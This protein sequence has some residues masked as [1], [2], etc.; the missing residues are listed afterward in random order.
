MPKKTQATHADTYTDITMVIARTHGGQTNY[1]MKFKFYTVIIIL[2]YLPKHVETSTAA[3]TLVRI[4]LPVCE[5][6]PTTMGCMQQL[7]QMNIHTR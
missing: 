3:K 2:M 6:K 1:L 5:N 4:P 7:H